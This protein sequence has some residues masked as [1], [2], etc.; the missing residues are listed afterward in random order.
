MNQ[1]SGPLSILC[2]EKRFPGESFYQFNKM[3]FFSDRQ[4]WPS[5]P[6]LSKS[7]L[8]SCSGSWHDQCDEVG[9]FWQRLMAMNKHVYLRVEIW[10][11]WAWLLMGT[12]IC[13]PKTQ[14]HMNVCHYQHSTSSLK[15][16]QCFILIR[17]LR[18]SIN[19]LSQW[20]AVSG[21]C[22]FLPSEKF[23]FNLIFFIKVKLSYTHIHR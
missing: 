14:T 8:W 22:T 18:H 10:L 7:L 4:Y 12:A 2:I 9:S 13:H 23:S 3:C 11:E 17:F 5:P 19:F 6:K 20:K 16:E 15:E 21:S 1:L